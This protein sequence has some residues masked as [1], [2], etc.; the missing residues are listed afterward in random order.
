MAK[1]HRRK[2]PMTKTTR[3]N[4]KL[5]EMEHKNC[6]IAAKIMNCSMSEVLRDGLRKTVKN[7][8]RR[9]DWP[10]GGKDHAD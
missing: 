9:G 5:T 4:L 1:L 2:T 10:E 3:L 6:Q 7:L 8:K